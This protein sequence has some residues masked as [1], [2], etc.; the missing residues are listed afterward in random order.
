MIMPLR[1]VYSL[2]QQRSGSL[3]FLFFLVILGTLLRVAHADGS[4]HRN[5][6]SI[7]RGTAPPPQPD[8]ASMISDPAAFTYAPNA[9]SMADADDTAQDRDIVQTAQVSP[10]SP[11]PEDKKKAPAFSAAGIQGTTAPSG[12]S[13]AASAEKVSEVLDLV[14]TLP[15]VDWHAALPSTEL[16]SCDQEGLLMRKYT[17]NPNDFNANYILGV[18]YLQHK[19]INESVRYLQR[20]AILRPNDPGNLRVLALSY[21]RAS[22][23]SEAEALIRRLIELDRHDPYPYLLLGDIKAVTDQHAEALAQYRTAVSLHPSDELLFACGLGLLRLGEI[24]YAQEGFLESQEHDPSSALLWI[25]RAIVEALHEE[26]VASAQSFLHAVSLDPSSSVPYPFLA[27]MAGLSSETDLQ[28]LRSVERFTTMHPDNAMGHYAYGVMLL[29]DGRSTLNEESTARA[30]SEF[31]RSLEIE[32]RFAKA[33]FELGT[34]YSSSGD[35]S[36]AAD[37]FRLA[38]QLEPRNADW[39]Y[40]LFRAY[41]CAGRTTLAEAELEQFKVLQSQSRSQVYPPV[42]ARQDSDLWEPRRSSC[43][44]YP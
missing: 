7:T 11:P 3:C 32:P 44:T 22:R 2:H 15:S 12:Y 33:H 40:R 37:E 18:F 34:I 4:L 31:R 5:G 6:L 41:K 23:Y 28:I 14:L 25:G 17:Q 35:C 42:E 43:R 30:E 10:G 19:N 20:A 16:L 13:A 27:R 39:R 29:G 1:N 21:I 36:V 9:V 8:N 38:V 26:R 24:R